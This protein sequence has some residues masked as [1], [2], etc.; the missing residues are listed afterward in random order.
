MRAEVKIVVFGASGGTGTNIVEQALQAGHVVTAFVR[1]P[2]KLGI[3][4]TNLS[5]FQGDVLD[6]ETVEQAIA[7]HEAVISVL[8]QTRPPVPDMMVTA[9]RNIVAGMEKR[10]VKRI[11]STTGGGVRDPLD[12]P[13]LFDHIMKALL[14]LM[15]GSV[16]KDLEANVNVIRGSNLDWTVV[17]YPRL[18]DGEHTG[19]YRVGYIGKDSGSQLSR[20]DGADFVLKELQTGEYLHKMPMVSY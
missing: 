15:A 6:A 13:K 4:H 3:E 1:S 9:A 10:G 17:R 16:L 8:G 7:G 5:I 20:A 11:I 14:T 12:Q 19:K 2:E 18:T